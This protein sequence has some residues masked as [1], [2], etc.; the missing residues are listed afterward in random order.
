[1]FSFSFLKV[2]MLYYVNLSGVCK[3]FV[4]SCF[5]FVNAYIIFTADSNFTLR[6][7]GLMNEHAGQM[8]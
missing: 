1:M 4:F 8:S 5:L 3:M 6:L 7:F 2:W